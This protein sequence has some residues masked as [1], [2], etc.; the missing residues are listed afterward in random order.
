MRAFPL[1]VGAFFAAAAGA[2]GSATAAVVVTTA[3]GAGA[4][5]YLSNDAQNAGQ[6]P[7][8]TH[9][10]ESTLLIRNFVDTRMK[11]A[12]VRFD[13]NNAIGDRSGSIL[14]FQILSTANRDRTFQVWGLTDNATDDAWNES[15][16]SYNTAPGV[17][18]NPPTPIAQVDI[19]ESKMTLLGTVGMIGS[20]AQVLRSDNGEPDSMLNLDSFLAADTNGLVTFLIINSTSDSNASYSIASKENTTPDVVLPTLELPNAV[21]VPEPAAVSS[22]GLAALVLLW[23]RGRRARAW[24]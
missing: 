4:D 13:L 21:P 11:M 1:L 9:G 23:R 2:A 16:T 12:Y 22:L 6:G 24:E 20:G 5:T 15:T 14:S 10:T 8:G 7:D 19:D 17:I 18:P 3:S